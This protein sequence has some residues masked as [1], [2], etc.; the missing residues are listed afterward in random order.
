ME[1]DD[2][3]PPIP[4]IIEF[5]ILQVRR[6][7]RGTCTHRMFEIDGE[8]GAVY[9]RDCDEEVPAFE[10]LCVIARHD[11]I[12]QRQYYRLREE[13]VELQK[14]KPWLKAVKRL[15]HVWRGKKMLPCCPHCN[16]GVRAEDL[17]ASG[18]KSIKYDQIRAGQSANKPPGP[19]LVED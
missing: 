17:A 7:N 1:D 19:E 18:M 11:S 8:A 5:K 12:F 16:R 6:R 15:E 4:Q 10:A 2:N 13:I 14:Y 9:C 3:L